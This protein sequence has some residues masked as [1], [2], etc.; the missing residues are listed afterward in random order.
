VSL[1]F[2][3][4]GIA[5]IWILMIVNEVVGVLLVRLLRRPVRRPLAY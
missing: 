1:C 4:F 2:L 5:M 3:G